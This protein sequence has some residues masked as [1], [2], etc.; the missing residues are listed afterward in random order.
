MQSGVLSGL[1]IVCRSYLYLDFRWW[2]LVD[3]R[4]GCR[5]VC[6]MVFDSHYSYPPLDDSSR[7]R[8]EEQ[9]N[10]GAEE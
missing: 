10:R 6:R 9:E 2:R 5:G 4:I 8:P 3:V 1:L 7:V